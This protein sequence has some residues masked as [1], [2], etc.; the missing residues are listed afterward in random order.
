MRNLKIKET[1]NGNNKRIINLEPFKKSKKKLTMEI[2]PYEIIRLIDW[3]IDTNFEI[4]NNSNYR[5]MLCL[6]NELK[7]KLIQ[8]ISF[9]ITLNL[10]EEKALKC[11]I[12]YLKQQDFLQQTTNY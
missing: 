6:Y 1:M 7:N 10:A 9:K 8:S 5:S 4:R 11:C 2:N 12:I 3:A